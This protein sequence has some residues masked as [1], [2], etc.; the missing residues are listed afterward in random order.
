MTGEERAMLRPLPRL[1]GWWTG[2]VSAACVFVLAFLTVGLVIIA[3]P[4]DPVVR[5]AV[6]V[7]VLAAPG[8]YGW[9]QWR[10]RSRLKAL[11]DAILRSG[12]AGVV[13]STL[14]TVTDA[15]AVEEREDEGRH[16]YLRLDDGRTLFLSGQYLY[17][18]VAQGFPWQSFEIV[19]VPGRDWVLKIVPLGPSITPSLTRP[20]FADVE[21]ESDAVPDDRTIATRDFEALKVSG[22][23]Q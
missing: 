16:Y 13:T 7:A 6:A 21:F 11:T 23:R 22:D 12:E 20:P 3:F 2:L 10:E 5:A 4:Y 19:A 17:D 1:F 9:V 14:Y 18:P 8:T 15:I